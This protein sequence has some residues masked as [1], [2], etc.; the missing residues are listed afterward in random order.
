MS[1]VWRKKTSLLAVLALTVLL[2]VC[3]E[4]NLTK[5]IVEVT[6]SRRQQPRIETSAD[7]VSGQQSQRMHSV[8]F[9]DDSSDG[10]EPAVVDIV[11]RS[12]DG[13]AY[14]NPR[15]A[16]VVDYR[17]RFKSSEVDYRFGSVDVAKV[18]SCLNW[19]TISRQSSN[20]RG[21]SFQTPYVPAHRIVHLDLKGAPPKISYLRQLFPFV[22]NLGAT[23]VLL[24]WEDMFPWEGNLVKLAAQNAYTKK[25]AKE[26]V[27]AAR[28]LDLEVIPLIQTFGHMEF[29]L[30]NGEFM[31]LREVPESPQSLCPS[32]NA[33]IVF[34][35]D[36][37]DQVSAKA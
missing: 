16:N 30:K 34:I 15:T 2:V 11:G 1:A 7:D 13:D 35:Q 4:Y 21:V 28:K 20:A 36:M 19:R 22:K 3:L 32:L 6:V 17:Q 27:K 10:E 37:I 9:V 29:A 14:Y 25:E 12:R 26:I 24:E 8:Q 18:R 5:E 31:H 33:S 23:G